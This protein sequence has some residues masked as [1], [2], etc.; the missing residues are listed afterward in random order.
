MPQYRRKWNLL[1]AASLVFGLAGCVVVEKRPG[2]PPP[3]APA[4]GYRAK[5][6]TYAIPAVAVHIKTV[7]EKGKGKGKHKK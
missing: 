5:Q 6:P 4:H 3:W 2:G 7:R 1:L